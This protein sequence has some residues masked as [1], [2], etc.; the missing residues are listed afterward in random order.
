MPSDAPAPEFELDAEGTID[1][2]WLMVLAEL[3]VDLA[4]AE[5]EREVAEDGQ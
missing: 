3:L 4:E 1:E 2:A 5:Q